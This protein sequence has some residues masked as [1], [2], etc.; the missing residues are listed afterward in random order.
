MINIQGRQKYV[1]TIIERILEIMV[2]I[3]DLFFNSSGIWC[4]KNNVETNGC[5]FHGSI[6]DRLLE[7]PSR[8]SC[9]MTSNALNDSKI[10]LHITV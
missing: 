7:L 6:S 3:R 8:E 9:Q 1:T 2:S 10:R 4:T 5:Q